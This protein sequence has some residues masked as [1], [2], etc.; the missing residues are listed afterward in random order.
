MT[1]TT[2]L[3]V[4]LG[5]V[6][7]TLRHSPEAPVW[8]TSVTST[9]TPAVLD[10]DLVGGCANPLVELCLSG[11][12]HSRHS[13]NVR[14]RNYSAS[15]RLRYRRHALRTV[16]GRAELVI[17]QRD[18]ESGVAV[19]TTLTQTTGATVR[20]ANRLV[21]EGDHAVVV[22]YISSLVLGGFVDAASDSAIDRLTV[23]YAHNAWSTEYRWRTATFRDLG[24]VDAGIS[25]AT[26]STRSTFAIG[27]VGSWSTGSSLPMAA[28]EDVASATTWLWQ[29]EHNGAWLAEFADVGPDFSA[30]ISGPT[31]RQHHWQERLAPGDE[32]ETVAVAI[33]VVHGDFDD[34]VAELTRH[35]RFS[36]R[37]H[38]DF[39]ST[40]V[41][42]N[43]YMNCLM[44]DPSTA[45]LLPLVDRAADAGAEYFVIDAG[46]YSD[47]SGWW[48][49][50]G[51]WEESSTRFPGGL[52][53]VID[54]IRSRGLVPGLWLEP[55][56]MGVNSPAVH[57]L[58]LEAY[59]Q[60]GGRP[61][62]EFDRYQLDFRH[63]LVIAR[64]NGVID[65]LVADYGIGYFKLDYNITI[66]EGTEVNTESLGSGLLGHNRAYLEWLAGLLDRHPQ[67]VL[68][69]C[70]SGAM[71]VDY[72]QLAVSQ[73][74]STSDQESP[75]L[76]AAI[77]AGA[78]TAITPEQS[79]VWSYPQPDWDID[80]NDFSLTQS[81]L[82]RVHLSGR[83]DQL[84][85]A[86]LG[87]VADAIAVHKTLRPFIREAL[88]FWPLGH[89]GWEDP[90]LGVGLRAG[91]RRVVAL[92]HRPGP[93]RTGDA[94]AGR[95][96][97]LP[98]P[99]GARGLRILYPT[100]RGVS[101]AALPG[102]VEVT[103]PALPGSAVVE[104][105]V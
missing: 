38:P 11:E 34:A 18:A 59:M 85:A 29:V 86:Q 63:P 5:G 60:R 96:V 72:A 94:D 39:K 102:G 25:H 28:I 104:W 26:S 33:A 101:V 71:R 58:P 74:Q 40:P 79:A 76:N 30:I 100:D 92:W 105:T 14:H 88:P 19:V 13:H 82:Q 53:E 24:F 47:D 51:A 78:M 27:A 81:M 98:A 95:T 16:D 103:I 41:I 61:V 45:A 10:E 31:F 80:T 6:R 70:S 8:L 12:S 32:F 73:L 4:E 3:D 37:P 97:R 50:V 99:D 20:I 65:R 22:D 56:V 35:R 91:S 49:T 87:R 9:D 55:E 1:V 69:S 54:R 75:L 2:H 66:A 36:R 15:H 84:D 17:E 46:W 93:A 62:A 90:W 7:F 21:N 64:M 89:G 83:L 42:F 67:L 43:D 48:S 23:H 68:E 57:E 77:A 44:G 52:G